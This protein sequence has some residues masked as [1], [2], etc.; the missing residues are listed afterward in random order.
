MTNTYLLVFDPIHGGRQT[1]LD[2]LDAIPEVADWHAPMQ[3]AV[4]V[5]SEAT[6]SELATRLRDAFPGITFVVTLIKPNLANGVL[7][8]A[9]WNFLL[10]RGRT[11]ASATSP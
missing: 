4:V 3:S 7:P 10:D 5:V 6:A 1:V 8:R 9:T 11:K 2:V